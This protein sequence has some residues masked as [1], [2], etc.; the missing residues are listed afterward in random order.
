MLDPFSHALPC[1]LSFFD[2]CITGN[3]PPKM[4]NWEGKKGTSEETLDVMF[5]GRPLEEPHVMIILNT[6]RRLSSTL[7]SLSTVTSQT[8]I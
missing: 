3:W 4:C 5:M 7:Y 6:D 2:F 8:H 1:F